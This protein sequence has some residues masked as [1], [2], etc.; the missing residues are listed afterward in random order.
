MR[1]GAECRPT[2]P[3]FVALTRSLAR[4]MD[5]IDDRYDIG[6]FVDEVEEHMAHDE[7]GEDFLTLASPDD[8][9]SFWMSFERSRALHDPR[10]P[11][12]GAVG[13]GVACNVAGDLTKRAESCWGEYD[14]V[15]AHGSK[16]SSSATLRIASLAG[17]PR[18]PAR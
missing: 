11:G 8:R 3:A 9:E 6:G 15:A 4:R 10:E 14:F 1:T 13:S 16:P 5:D 7:P 17:T 2:S 12:T 18:S